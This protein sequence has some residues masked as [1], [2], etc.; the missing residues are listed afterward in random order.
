MKASKFLCSLDLLAE[1][2]FNPIAWPCPALGRAGCICKAVVTVSSPPPLPLLCLS[3]EILGPRCLSPPSGACESP[4]ALRLWPAFLGAAY[5]FLKSLR[6]ELRKPPLGSCRGLW[7]LKDVCSLSS[8]WQ[9][10]VLSSAW[11]S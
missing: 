9:N 11:S 6:K 1:L 5:F 3:G 10:L 7:S 4:V 2:H 8:F